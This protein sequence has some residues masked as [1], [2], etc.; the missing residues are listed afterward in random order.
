M[1]L[2][3]VA[4]Q[5]QTCI[6]VEIDAN[7]AAVLAVA[8]GP[9]VALCPSSFGSHDSCARE[10]CFS[11]VDAR[12]NDDTIPLDVIFRSL[13]TLEAQKRFSRRLDQL[14]QEVIR[15][16]EDQDGPMYH[17][18]TTSVSG[19]STSTSSSLYAAD[20][21]AGASANGSRFMSVTS[22]TSR[23]SSSTYKSRSRDVS[24]LPRSVSTDSTALQSAPGGIA[25]QLVYGSIS[26]RSVDLTCEVEDDVGKKTM[27]NFPQMTSNAD[28]VATPRS[29]AFPTDPSPPKKT[30]HYVHPPKVVNEEISASRKRHRAPS[31]IDLPEQDHLKPGQCILLSNARKGT[32][33]ARSREGYRAAVPQEAH[34]GLEEGA[35]KKRKL[36]SQSAGPSKAVA[37]VV[38]SKY[39]AKE[40]ASLRRAASLRSE[41]S[42]ATT[43]DPATQEKAYLAVVKKEAD[44]TP[45]HRSILLGDGS[46]N[47]PPGF[48]PTEPASPATPNTGR[49]SLPLCPPPILSP[50]SFASGRR[51]PLSGI[52]AAERRLLVLL[53]KELNERLKDG[54]PAPTTETPL[55][56]VSLNDSEDELWRAVDSHSTPILLDGKTSPRNSVKESRFSSS[57]VVKTTLSLGIKENFRMKVVDW[58]IEVIN[59]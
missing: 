1:E 55:A 6:K 28:Q 59:L 25:A 22:A 37:P 21:S 34:S 8:P 9:N 58:I 31:P 5:T 32:V 30:Q 54:L 42:K 43:L 41:A 7:N 40:P 18:E 38:H 3:P 44:A 53:K 57:D 50:S 17:G 36:S 39:F 19:V 15:D 35:V 23:P 4:S 2:T 47:L 12:L 52:D 51:P 24:R 11:S 20:I 29:T 16:S 45:D 10:S 26:D 48:I 56:P 13:E 33:T 14:L 27:M 49:P 46:K